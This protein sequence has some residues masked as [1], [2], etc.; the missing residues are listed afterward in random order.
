[1]KT[2]Q[3]KGDSVAAL[4]RRFCGRWLLFWG[5]VWRPA[6]SDPGDSTFAAWRKYRI[7][8]AVAWEVCKTLYRP[9]AERELVAS[10][11]KREDIICPSCRE[12]NP[13]VRSGLCSFRCGRCGESWDAA[14]VEKRKRSGRC[15][16]REIAPTEGC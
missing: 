14:G 1:M 10:L 7:T 2:K 16:A 9:N 3:E 15:N 6:T 8:P 11:P 12:P 5:I 4:A 13:S